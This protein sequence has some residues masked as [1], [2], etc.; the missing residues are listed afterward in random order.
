MT[1]KFNAGEQM[2]ELDGK[3][4]TRPG[5]DRPWTMGDAAATAVIAGKPGMAASEHF[6]RYDLAQRLVQGGEVELSAEEI[7]MIKNAVL[8][9]YAPIAAVPIMRAIG[10]S[11]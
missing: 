11:A 10:A 8:E 1:S 5:D 9:Q 4:V 2:F 7:V 3:S 6:Q